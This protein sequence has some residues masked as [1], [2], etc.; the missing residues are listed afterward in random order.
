MSSSTIQTPAVTDDELRE[1]FRPIFDRIAEGAVQREHERR[2]PFH[3][4]Q[5]LREARFGALRVPVE[6]G[7]FGATIRQLFDLLIDLAAAESNLPQALRVHWSFV[8]DQ[9]L[10]GD[11]RARHW[12]AAA[13]DGTLVGNAITEPGVGA[14]DRYRTTLTRKGGDWALD[15]IKYYSTGSLYADHILVAADRDGERVS[16]LVDARQEGVEQT[17]DWDGFG[18]RLTAS[19]TTT[20]TG[21]VVPEDRILGPGYG[22]PG[23]TYATAYLQLVQLA[24]LAGIAR[25]AEADAVDWVRARTRTFTHAV[26]DLPRH[27]PLVQQVIGKL[28]AAAFGARAAVLAVADDLDVL[29]DAGADDPELLDRAEASAARAQSVVIGLVLDATAQLFEVGGASITSSEAA[30]DRHWRN[31]RTVAAH[32]PLIYKQQAV[33][34]HVLNGDPLPYAWSAGRRPGVIA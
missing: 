10:A 17:D 16:V 9:R 18:Q 34:A 14:A 28:S 32:N 22:A 25:R 19:G 30:L 27:D 31:A 1:R 15:G 23:R 20:F 6:F 11:E 4:V 7:G 13:A 33:G 5:W 29:L 21:V 12:L 3:E 26:A 8:E 2:L 24:V